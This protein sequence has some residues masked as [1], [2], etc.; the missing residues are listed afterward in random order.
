M[1]KTW[2]LLVN[3][4]IMIAMLAFVVFYSNRENKEIT[5]RQIS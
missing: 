1:K 5:Q 3:V 2:V 4:F